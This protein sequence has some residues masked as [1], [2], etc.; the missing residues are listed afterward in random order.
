MSVS[1]S[2][3]E[4]LARRAR[5]FRPERAALALPDEGDFLAVDHALNASAFS[6]GDVSY[7]CTN[8][9]DPDFDLSGASEFADDSSLDSFY[10]DERVDGECV[11]DS[12]FLDTEE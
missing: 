2:R 10:S 7:F 3:S 8:T 6:C 1:L 5:S 11:P 4:R 9:V 12:S